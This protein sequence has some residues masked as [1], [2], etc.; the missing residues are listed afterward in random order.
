M[1]KSEKSLHCQKAYE[2]GDQTEVERGLS[3]E[4]ILKKTDRE[5]ETKKASSSFLA[6][7]ITFHLWLVV[8]SGCTSDNFKLPPAL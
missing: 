7:F 3:P 8:E 1:R 4:W 5:R 2:E 6:A